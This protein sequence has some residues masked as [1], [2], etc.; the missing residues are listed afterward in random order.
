MDL[1]TRGMIKDMDRTRI[2]AI[3]TELAERAGLAVVPSVDEVTW[4][5]NAGIVRRADG[6][7][8]VLG[9]GLV[10]ALSEA[11]D[12]EAAVRV[13]AAH[14][15][16]HIAASDHRSLAG[17]SH[18]RAAFGVP[19][20]AG[21]VLVL[22]GGDLTALAVGLLA[23]G[24]ATSLALALQAACARRA[25]LA[26]DRYATVLTGAPSVA[27]GALDALDAYAALVRRYVTARREVGLVTA[28]AG[29]A[30]TPSELRRRVLLLEARL[31]AEDRTP[32]AP[33]PEGGLD[34]FASHPSTRA[35]V[36]AL[37]GLATSY[38]GYDGR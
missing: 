21:L 15:L 7:H 19:V 27:L 12:P 26:A 4:T 8:L 38:G 28:L 31:A 9:G 24:I 5:V 34:P 23:G 10:A 30:L 29:P 6:P 32:L 22:F 17:R 2:E 35:R 16:G 11:P 1:V 36:R 14:E 18:V 20:A 25:E 13:I 37:R 3:V 33:L